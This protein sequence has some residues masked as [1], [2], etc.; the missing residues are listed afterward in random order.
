MYCRNCANEM[1][2][3]SSVCTK[4]GVR[5]GNGNLYCPSCGNPTNENAEI[6]VNCGINLKKKNFVSIAS[7]TSKSGKSKLVA[8]V[9]CLL[10]GY[11][12]MHRFYVNDNVKGFII[13]TLTLAGILTCGITTMISCIWVLVDFVLI[14]LD[15]ITDENGQPLQW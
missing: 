6:C 10:L 3:E 15:K 13:L 1:N 4:C 7:N 2:S 8:S 9:L 12:G 11:C 5:K 14:I